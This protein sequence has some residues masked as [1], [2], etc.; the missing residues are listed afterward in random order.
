MDRLKKK[1]APVRATFSRTVNQLELDVSA[2]LLDREKIQLSMIKL[3]RLFRE[4]C[5]LDQH[6]GDLLLDGDCSEEDYGNERAACDEYHEKIEL[7]RLKVETVMNP[8][9]KVQSIHGVSSGESE[10][11]KT[12]SRSSALRRRK[13]KL[14]RLEFKKFSGDVKDG[15]GE[16]SG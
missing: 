8:R 3:E 9:A 15:H 2:E 14:P 10:S 5:E 7:M 16:G 13:F 4:L 1:R 12:N 11:S 6:F